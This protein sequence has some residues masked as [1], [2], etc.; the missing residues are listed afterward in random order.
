[1]ELKKQRYQTNINKQKNKDM[2]TK[3][4][5]KANLEKKRFLFLELGL[6]LALGICFAAFEWSSPE[7]NESN[8]ANESNVTFMED[9]VIITRPQTPPPPPAIEPPN[10]VAETITITSKPTTDAPDVF[11]EPTGPVL[12]IIIKPVIV[13][14]IDDPVE[15]IDYVKVEKKPVFPGGDAALLKF[16]ADHTKYPSIPLENNVKGKVYIQFVIGVDG[17]VGSVTVA[18]S[19]D[20]YLDKEAV[21]VISMLP[22]WSAGS[23]RGK[24]VPVSFI[25]PINFN[26]E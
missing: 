14:V 15:I 10:V 13:P 1:M 18:K 23:Q 19:V 6:V 17:K 26:I 21:R 9:D 4:T 24:N 3:K 20:Y 16:I 2:K 8:F 22:D 7:V 12:P 25:I 5:I 11:D